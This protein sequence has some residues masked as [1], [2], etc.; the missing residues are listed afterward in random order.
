MRGPRA[1]LV[2]FTRAGLIR[3]RAAALPPRPEVH[4]ASEQGRGD[5]H[6][7][8]RGRRH[9]DRGGGTPFADLL[10]LDP[11][12]AIDVGDVCGAH[13]RLKVAS[14]RLLRVC[15]EAALCGGGLRRRRRRD[16]GNHDDAS[17]GD[18]EGGA[19]R[20]KAEPGQLRESDEDQPLR[21]GV[22]VAD[23]ATCGEGRDD[24]ERP[25]LCRRRRRRPRGWRCGWGRWGGR[26]RG[27]RRQQRWRRRRRQRRRRR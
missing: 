16:R 8:R 18:L 2:A 6:P 4:A 21:G 1:H 15:A 22:I 14:A 25:R 5:G 19:E 10:H 11:E 17:G 26:Q 27:R 3:G 20:H 9:G 24:P 7:H 12:S 23:F 13:S